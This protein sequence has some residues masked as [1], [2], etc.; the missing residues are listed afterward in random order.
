MCDSSA[1]YIEESRACCSENG[2]L[3]SLRCRHFCYVN[4]L[5]RQ[6]GA[7]ARDVRHC[8][9][10]LN[11]IR[12]VTRRCDTM[13]RVSHRRCKDVSPRRERKS[14]RKCIC[15]GYNVTV[16]ASISH[17]DVS[18]RTAASLRSSTGSAQAS[19]V[20]ASD[21]SIVTNLETLYAVTLSRYTLSFAFP[22]LVGAPPWHYRSD[23]SITGGTGGAVNSTAGAAELGTAR[24]GSD[25]R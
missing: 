22:A 15:S 20:S 12:Y 5:F 4:Q 8:Q 17:T 2:C 23:I 21:L 18:P 10:D 13:P 9:R 16:T 25:Q 19:T 14:Q 7:V 1:C 3:S 6:R 24:Q 11:G